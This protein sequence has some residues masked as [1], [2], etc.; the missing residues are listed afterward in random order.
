[1]GRHRLVTIQAG[2]E[3][4]IVLE[5]MKAAVAALTMVIG[6]FNFVV[7][8]LSETLDKCHSNCFW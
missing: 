1:M 4:T 8:C 2:V 5:G 6:V 3:N 7:N